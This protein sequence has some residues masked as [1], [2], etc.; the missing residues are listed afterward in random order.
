MENFPDRFPYDNRVNK[1]KEKK[2][3]PFLVATNVI[4]SLPP[5]RRMTGTPHA[6]AN[7]ACNIGSKMFWPRFFWTKHFLERREG[8]KN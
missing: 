3:M 1:E 4:A 5:E 7:I 6:R 2:I 8:F